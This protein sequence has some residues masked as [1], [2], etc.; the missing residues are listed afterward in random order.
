MAQRK[1]R[2]QVLTITYGQVPVDGVKDAGTLVTAYR[3]GGVTGRQYVASFCFPDEFGGVSP[4]TGYVRIR[5]V[6]TLKDFW[7]PKDVPNVK[8]ESI[9]TVAG[10][11]GVKRPKSHFRLNDK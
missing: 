4:R 10:L 3:K 7:I 5:S 11:L 8:L 6:E 9:A 2:R 1:A